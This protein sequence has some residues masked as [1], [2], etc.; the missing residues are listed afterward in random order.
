MKPWHGRETNLR[1]NRRSGVITYRQL[2]NRRR[3]KRKSREHS[4]TKFG[5]SLRVLLNLQL[6]GSIDLNFGNKLPIKKE[7]MKC[8]RPSSG[9]GRSAMNS[10]CW[11]C[12]PSRPET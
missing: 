8:F 6:V 10:K 2:D 3:R 4:G 1:V 12:N 11:R 5:S 7:K 9:I